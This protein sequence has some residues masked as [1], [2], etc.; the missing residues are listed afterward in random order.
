M[1][2][3]TLLSYGVT[4][5][6]TFT[7]YALAE[8]RTSDGH[9]QHDRSA[10]E[11]H[12]PQNSSVQRD[13]DQ[14]RPQNS[15]V[16]RDRDLYRPQNNSVQRDSGQG[17]REQ[18]SRDQNNRDS[19]SQWRTNTVYSRDNR[20]QDRR[21]NVN[22]QV[23]RQ[24]D[25]APRNDQNQQQS[26]TIKPNAFKP[27]KPYVTRSRE[28]QPAH[29]SV[30]RHYH[31]V[32]HQPYRYPVTSMQYRH[33]NTYDHR[34]SVTYHTHYY[35]GAHY[36]AAYLLGGVVLGVLL[37]ERTPL[38]GYYYNDGYRDYDYVN[39]RSDTCYQSFYRDGR[40]MLIEVDRYYCR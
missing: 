10:R 19:N 28:L 26:Y 8:F 38:E 14:H 15:F 17:D 36:D 23:W 34:H 12:R 40:R 3:N 33:W 29:R 7:P 20:D 18:R 6:M 16:Q 27:I 24:S 39:V 31:P 35:H 21:G 13:R 32:V 11:S 4:I 22:D 9:A 1:K 2:L 37:S 30:D 5:A 25:H